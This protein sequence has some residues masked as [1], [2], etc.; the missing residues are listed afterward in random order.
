MT[1]YQE[2]LLALAAESESAALEL[3]WQVDTLG[4]ALFAAALA[5]II[6]TYSGRAITLA[7]LAFAAQASIA[8][9]APVPAVA[10]LPAVDTDRLAQAATTV[11]DVARASDVPDSIIARLARAEPLN[12]AAQTFS[13]QVAD[14]PLVEGWTRQMDADPCQLCTWWWREGR[15]W[16]KEHPF[17]THTGCACVPRPVWVK[18]IKSTGYTRK[19]R[20]IA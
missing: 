14:S 16:P 15:I 2:T 18:N 10:V 7:S 8:T 13:G 20:T 19:L 4:D 3:W 6:A 1:P 9:G 12:T 17:Q 5:A 11:I